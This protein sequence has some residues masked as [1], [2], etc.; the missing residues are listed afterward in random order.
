MSKSNQH[1]NDYMLL[2]FNNVAAAG[3][4]DAGGLRPSVA[5]G[6]FYIALHT[7]D[8]G[9]A[10]TQATAEATYTGYT[11]MAVARTAAG[12]TVTANAVNLV[13]NLDFP[14]CTANPGA[15]LTHFSIGDDASGAGKIRYK[16]SLSPVVTTAV[17]VVPRLSTAA[18]LVTED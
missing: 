1:E 9:E 15:P 5:A 18:N 16:G 4:G 2:M 3:I 13:A 17:G 10:G 8:P 14:Q 11:R 12:F 6:N 7:G